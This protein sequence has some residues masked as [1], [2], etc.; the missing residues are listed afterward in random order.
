MP[1]WAVDAFESPKLMPSLHQNSNYVE[2]NSL[3]ASRPDSEARVIA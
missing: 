2:R 3:V 1:T